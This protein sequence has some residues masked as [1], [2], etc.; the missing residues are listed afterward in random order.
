MDIVSFTG[1][2][3]VGGRASSSRESFLG[4][5][6]AAGAEIEPPFF[7]AGPADIDR[8]CNEAWAAFDEFRQAP[9]ETRARF[10]ET[11]AAN[12]AAL[13]EPLIHRAMTETG[14]PKARLEGECQRTINQLRLFADVVR[15]GVWL[16]LRIDTALP[17]RVPPRSDLRMRKIPLGPVAIF[18]ASNFPLAFSVAGGDT[19]SAIAAGCPV[20]VKAHPAHPGTGEMIARAIVKAVED[21]GLP[22]G[23]FSYLAGKSHELG[24]ALVSHP[25]IKAVGFT[26]S[27]AGGLALCAVAAARPEP[28]P[29]FAEMSSV[30]PIFLLPGALDGDAEK[31]A[32]AFVGS[33]TLGAGQFC[34]NPGL[35]FA[36]KGPG[37]DRFIAAATAALG[38]SAAQTMLTEGIRKAY[39][40]GVARLADAVGVEISGRG[41]ACD[42]AQQGHAALFVTDEKNFRSNPSLAG[43]VFGPSSVI[44]RCDSADTLLGIVEGLEGQLTAAIH[45]RDADSALA[46]RLIPRL[47]HK[48][49]RIL[50]NGWPTGVEVSHA[51]VHG[52]PFPA[53]SDGRSTSVGSLAIDRFLRPVCYQ[54]IPD[55]LLPQELRAGE[56]GLEI[57]IDGVR[58]AP[59][60]PRR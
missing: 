51:M 1:E 46:S 50:A 45:L 36:V 5:D 32:A 47:E 35:V 11:I 40:D 18:G 37:L 25:H 38:N 34:T 56:T 52:G 10:L 58:V 57:L 23:I 26:G 21:C 48:V 42:G 14:L 41:K 2:F 28:I 39:D 9:L 22:P 4:S 59:E 15:Q 17:A 44:V 3:F 53:T 60:T 8:A 54:D 6:A 27:R 7:I 55:V 19:A 31:I 49:G 12:I 13:G 33:L 30:N 16:S 29:V 20:V 24:A 43:E